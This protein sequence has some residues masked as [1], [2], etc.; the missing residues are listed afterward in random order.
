MDVLMQLEPDVEIYSI[1]EA[2]IAFSAGRYLDLEKYAAFL[3]NTVQQ[4]TGIPVSIGFGPTK[5]LAKIANR[6]AKKNAANA[7]VLALSDRSR[8]ESLLGATDVGDIWGI[9]RRYAERLKRQ[10]IH[11]A[12]ELAR[13]DDTWIRKQLTVAGL[14]TVMELRGISCISLE[15]AKPAKKSITTS[16]SFGHPVQTLSDLQEAV[17]TY[18]A[19]SAPLL[20]MSLSAPTVSRKMNRNTATEKPLCC[21]HPPPILRP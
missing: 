7:S 6:F 14:R 11:T 16:R 3:K 10:S 2:F 13:C 17:A 18:A 4:N 5:T 21:N 20:S 9:G 19:I 8:L 1:D 15:E 12:L